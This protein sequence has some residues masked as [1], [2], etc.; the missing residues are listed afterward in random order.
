MYQTLIWSAVA[1]D[2]AGGLGPA[3]DPQD[4]ERAAD[5]LVDGMRGDIELCR[6]FLGVQMLIDEPQAIELARA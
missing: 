3:L 2:D 4:L 1:G 5:A 6:D